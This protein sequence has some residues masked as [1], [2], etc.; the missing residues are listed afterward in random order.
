M[1]RNAAAALVAAWL[2]AGGSGAIVAA[3]IPDLAPVQAEA[4]AP[5]AVNSCGDGVID[6]EAG[7]QCDPGPGAGDAGVGGCS[8]TC[9]M[10]CPSGM[11]PWSSNNHCYQIAG[12]AGASQFRGA[13]TACTGGSHVVTFASELEFL[14][15]LSLGGGGGGA[16]WVGLDKA[17]AG[18]NPYLPPPSLVEPGWWWTCPGCFAHGAPSDADLTELPDAAVEGGVYDCVAALADSVQSWQRY[19]CRGL[20]QQTLGVVCELEPVGKQSKPCEAGICIDL[21]KTYGTKSYLYQANLALPADASRV[22]V[23]LGGQLVVLQSG[24][25]RE[26]LWRELSRLTAPPSAVW[27][28]L[29]QTTPAS[30]RVPEGVWAWDDHTPAQGTG[31]YPAEWAATRLRYPQASTTR[32]FLY[33]DEHAPAFDDTLAQNNPSLTSSGMLPF[34]CE[35]PA[36]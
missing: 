19:P 15:V 14:H 13:S 30:N 35:I 32:A 5:V 9:Q 11:P 3:C 33:H 34:V 2:A 4:G 31:A 25:E 18:S 29:S 24:D 20:T 27:I 17:T 10:Q 7:E 36:R 16:F 26:Q 23:A 12:S 8:A 22:C 1:D 28:G 6:L 21:V